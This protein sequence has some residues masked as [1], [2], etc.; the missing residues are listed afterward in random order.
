MS[1]I[2]DQIQVNT[3]KYGTRDNQFGQFMH[4]F[5]YSLNFTLISDFIYTFLHA[6]ISVFPDFSVNFCI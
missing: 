2:E 3:D 1:C 6:S 5:T 4:L